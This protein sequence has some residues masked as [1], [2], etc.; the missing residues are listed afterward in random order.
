VTW[1]LVYVDPPVSHLTGGF[2][3]QEPDS[4]SLG[5]CLLVLQGELRWGPAG[6]VAVVRPAGPVAVLPRGS[7]WGSF[8]VGC[9]FFLL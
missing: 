1:Q 2:A 3:P 9:A 5:V 6:G 8:S 7:P 4:C